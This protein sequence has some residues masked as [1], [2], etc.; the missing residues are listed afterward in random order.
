MWGWPLGSERLL[1]LAV[2]LAG[3]PQGND[4][5]NGTQRNGVGVRF[6]LP[7][8]YM[9]EP[10]DDEPGDMM[11]GHLMLDRLALRVESV[12]FEGDGPEGQVS[13][14]NDK[15]TV[16]DVVTGAGE[17][18]MA[19]VDLAQGVYEPADVSVSLSPDSTPSVHFE[20][21]YEETAIELIV[22]DALTLRAHTDHF[23]LPDGPD[24][25]VQF[26]L[27]AEDWF[28]DLPLPEV[29]PGDVVVISADENTD[30]Y[31]TVVARI[32]ATTEGHFPDGGR[33]VRP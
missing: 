9:E 12:L 4:T 16:V 14:S 11:E 24:P 6:D 27:H 31:D 33:H 25:I 20:G 18:D 5:G 28:H 30:L 8:A 7:D 23:L 29:P 22:T 17:A 10:E 13:T 3:C 19:V 32:A 21:A 15:V 1:F 2:L 26:G